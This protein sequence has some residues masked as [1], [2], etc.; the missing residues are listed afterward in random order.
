MSC[1]D[2][3][4]CG[5]D[6]GECPQIN[7]DELREQ[8]RSCSVEDLVKLMQDVGNVRPESASRDRAWNIRREWSMRMRVQ[9]KDQSFFCKRC[10]TLLGR[11]TERDELTVRF[12]DFPSGDEARYYFVFDKIVCDCEREMICPHE[13]AYDPPDCPPNC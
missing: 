12:L 5:H 8:L 3:P 1:A 10:G 11:L 2:Y 9:F 13:V 4:C 6:S 7:E